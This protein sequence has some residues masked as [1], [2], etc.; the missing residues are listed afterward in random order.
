MFFHSIIGG[1]IL[2]FPLLDVTI[3][4]NGKIK[5]NDTPSSETLLLKN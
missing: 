3:E 1:K 2:I 5:Q 4:S